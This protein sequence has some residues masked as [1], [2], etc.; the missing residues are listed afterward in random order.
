MIEK[1]EIY[2]KINKRQI[3]LYFFLLIT[4]QIALF[5]IFIKNSVNF[6]SILIFALLILIIP[7]ILGFITPKIIRIIYKKE[8]EEVE[9]E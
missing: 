3:I 4:I 2:K 9:G 8:L 7:V 5:L 6:Y 1:R